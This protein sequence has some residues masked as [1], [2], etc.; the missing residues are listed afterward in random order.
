MKKT[1]LA[2]SVIIPTFNRKEKLFNK[3]LKALNNQNF[4]IDNFE[5]LII[6]DGSSDGT[7]EYFKKYK[8][9]YKYK[10]KY[11]Y[12]ENKG[13]G[14]A[15]NVGIRQAGADILLFIGDD[16]I[17]TPDLLK[18]HMDFH[19]EYPENNIGMLGYITWSPEIEVIPFMKWLENSGTQFSYYRL[20]HGDKIKEGFFWTCNISLKKSFLLNN[21]GFFDE[22]F[23]YA[24]YEDSELGYRLNKRGLILVYNKNALGY[25]YHYSDLSSIRKRMFIVGKSAV[26]FQSKHP[27][28]DILGTSAIRIIKSLV[29]K[30]II[31]PLSIIIL[32]KIAYHCQYRYNLPPVYKAVSNFYLR[33]GICQGKRLF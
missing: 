8:D 10:I 19:H 15:R 27:E 5:V 30:I 23:P 21:N 4:P 14:T 24:A 28:M 2:I 17:A 7:K 33:K 3:T 13:P 16:I 12:Q 9:F 6:D 29:L 26:I 11:F 25:H 31:N 22:D 32:E 1:N 18:K 20:K